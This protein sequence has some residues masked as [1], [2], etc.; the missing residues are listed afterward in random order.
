[1]CLFENIIHGMVLMFSTSNQ[2][3][4]L[5]HF[6]NFLNM[7]I[8]EIFVLFKW[9]VSQRKTFSNLNCEWSL[10][11]G[12]RTP[13][14][15]HVEFLRGSVQNSLLNLSGSSSDAKFSSISKKKKCFPFQKTVFHFPPSPLT[16]HST[17]RRQFSP[18]LNLDFLNLPRFYFCPHKMNSCW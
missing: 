7:K 18:F 14:P 1:M 5:V 6:T 3:I 12:H 16:F 2:N 4:W 10:N 9:T 11:Y 13:N 15:I 17:P 8:V